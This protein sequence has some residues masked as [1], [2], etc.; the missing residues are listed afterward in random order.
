[1]LKLNKYENLNE[2]MIECISM[3]H[4]KPLREAASSAGKEGR[5]WRVN[6]GREIKTII[7]LGDGSIYLCPLNPDTYLS[8]VDGTNYIVADPK[9]IILRRNMVVNITTHPT[10]AQHKAIM[11]K[12]TEGKFYDL[13]RGKKTNYYV[14]TINGHI[15]GLPRIRENLSD[16]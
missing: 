11:D 2:D 9:R 4:S 10:R 15:Y 3:Y 12:R 1:M 7:I 14:F 13:T 16:I 5:C 6:M 8:R